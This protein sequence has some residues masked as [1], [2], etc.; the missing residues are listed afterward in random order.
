MNKCAWCDDT[1]EN[2]KHYAV[3]VRE[4][5]KRIGRL[6]PDGTCNR[7][8]I[9][10]AVMSEAKAFDIAKDINAQGGNT[11]EGLHATPILF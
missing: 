10:A 5:G 6:T 9:Y 1:R 4:N 11:F 3:S 8:N 7:L 2:H